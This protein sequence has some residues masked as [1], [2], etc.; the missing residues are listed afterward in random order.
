MLTNKCTNLCSRVSMFSPKICIRRNRKYA[1]HFPESTESRLASSAGGREGP[2]PISTLQTPPPLQ[3]CQHHQVYISMCLCV[4]IFTVI[5][6]GFPISS[7]DSKCFYMHD[8]PS[9]TRA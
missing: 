4:S 7:L 9:G 8:Q 3:M 1:F 5:F 6:K 2:K